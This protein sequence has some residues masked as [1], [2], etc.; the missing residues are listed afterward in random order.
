MTEEQCAK[1]RLNGKLDSNLA[2]LSKGWQEIW[3]PASKKL[4]IHIN[5]VAGT[6][7]YLIKNSKK[8]T[9]K[10]QHSLEGVQSLT[11]YFTNYSRRWRKIDG[12]HYI[13]QYNIDFFRKRFES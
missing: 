6:R 12:N 8:I 4:N 9:R 10:Q 13:E 3:I 2:S 7:Q 1:W 5:N 11:D